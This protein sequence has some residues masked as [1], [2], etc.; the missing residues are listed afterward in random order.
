MHPIRHSVPLLALTTLLVAIALGSAN[1]GSSSDSTQAVIGPTGGSLSLAGVR[2]D[3]PAGALT[4]QT[5]V[6]LRTSNVPGALLVGIEPAQLA[7]GHQATLGVQFT[8]KV[9]VSGV[10]DVAGGALGV[11]LRMENASGAKVRLRLDRFTQVRLALTEVS[12]GGTSACCGGDDCGDGERG[13]GGHSDG[14]H[15]DGEKGDGG[16]CDGGHPDGEHGDG[17]TGDGEH[18]DGDHGDGDHHDGEHGDGGM[19]GSAGCPA[20]FECDDGV[21]V[22]PGGND[23]ENDDDDCGEH[24]DQ[25]GGMGASCPAGSH[26][27]DGKCRPD[28]ADAGMP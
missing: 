13:D 10:T 2:L 24:G 5:T 14:E 19:V 9:H 21:C 25:D 3:V 12:D 8:G 4:Q 16:V 28:A 15:G 1:C 26:C 6:T 17:G 11:D 22:A 7:L 20:G 27:S 18:G 23:E